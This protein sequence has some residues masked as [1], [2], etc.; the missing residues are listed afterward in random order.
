MERENDVID[1]KNL[2]FNLIN[3]N[4]RSLCPKVNSLLDCFD[5]M[6]VS[7]A[8]ITET[9]LAD[10]QGLDED[11]DDLLEGAGLGMLYRNR[12]PG[13]RGTSHGGVAVLYLSL[14]HI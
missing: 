6:G 11:V 4:A 1:T 7:L 3:T 14:I 10:G 13:R 2:Q 8:V 5:E 9:W 12:P